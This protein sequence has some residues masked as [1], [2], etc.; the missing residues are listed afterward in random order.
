MFCWKVQLWENLIFGALSRS[1]R[2][3]LCS[4]QVLRF[5]C[6]LWCGVLLHVRIAHT[7]SAKIAIL[8]K[9]HLAGHK[10]AQAFHPPCASARFD[11]QVQQTHKLTWV[12]DTSAPT[13]DSSAGASCVCVSGYSAPAT[14]NQASCNSANQT[15]ENENSGCLCCCATPQH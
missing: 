6:L 11:Q 8:V 15:L 10:A 4:T 1:L 13:L 12:L 7:H 3:L 5:Y 2:A 14:K 9:M